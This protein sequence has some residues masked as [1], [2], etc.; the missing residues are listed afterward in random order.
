MLKKIKKKKLFENLTMAPIDKELI[1]KENLNVREKNGLM[2]TI[3]M[4]LKIL[5]T[6]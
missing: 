4:F 5:K 3:K 6:T 1:I 2:I